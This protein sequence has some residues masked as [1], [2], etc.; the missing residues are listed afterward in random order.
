MDRYVGIGEA[1]AA[2]HDCVWARKRHDVVLGVRGN[3]GYG[4]LAMTMPFVLRLL[5][6]RVGICATAIP[7]NH[8]HRRLFWEA[9]FGLS[10]VPVPKAVII[11]RRRSRSQTIVL[12]L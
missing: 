6:R 4:L 2:L 3:R 11:C 1:A 8:R 7:G 10:L 12:C 5:I 9:M